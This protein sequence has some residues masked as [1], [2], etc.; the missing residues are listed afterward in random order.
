MSRSAAT[1]FAPVPTDWSVRALRAR[2]QVLRTSLALPNVGGGRALATA[3]E[4]AAYWPGGSHNRQRGRGAWI[5]CW[6][7]YV[8]FSRRRETLT[9]RL[10]LDALREVQAKALTGRP[11]LV[12][13]ADGVERAVY[14]KSYPAH[15]V[16]T[17]LDAAI[18]HLAG[19][20]LLEATLP[21]H[22]GAR[23]QAPVLRSFAVRLWLWAVTHPEA[24]LPFDPYAPGDGVEPPAW[25]N[26]VMVQDLPAF[27]AAFRRANH[28]AAEVLAAA[29]PP[30]PA[31][32]RRLSFEGMIGAYAASKNQDPLALLARWSLVRVL[33]TSV[34]EAISHED[35]ERRAK[36]RRDAERGGTA[37]PTRSRAR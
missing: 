16:C 11:E 5:V 3:A 10:D 32:E 6:G 7:N 22:V 31:A 20:E 21:E 4:L 35:A 17:A 18:R 2:C 34:S 19:V 14:Q 27:V 23:T 12:R 37:T 28:D 24:G 25:T 9:P 33:A 15:E 1:A 29:F 30:D 13:C 26:V 36:A 8:A